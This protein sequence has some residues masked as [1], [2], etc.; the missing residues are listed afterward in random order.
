MYNILYQYI[1]LNRQLGLPGI[2]TIRLVQN[3]AQLDIGNKKFLAPFQHFIL[4][5]SID[6]PAD[7][8]FEWLSHTLKIENWDAIKKVNEFSAN[9]K[10]SITQSGDVCWE[11]IGVLHRDEKGTIVLDTDRSN[12]QNRDSVAAHKIIR[13]KQEHSILVGESEKSSLEMEELLPIKPLHINY[14][15]R[16]AILITILSAGLIG[17]QFSSKKI[18]LSSLGNQVVMQVK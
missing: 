13:E 9:L 12:L 14:A 2:G 6:K 5:H 17:W 7:K 10:N 1:L 16:A 15:W 18:T 4:D 8:L 3:S 11:K